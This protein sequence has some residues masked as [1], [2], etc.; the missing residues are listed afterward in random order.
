MSSL[1]TS[2]LIPNIKT[3]SSNIFSSNFAIG[4]AKLRGK[5]LVSIF[6]S[7]EKI[8]RESLHDECVKAKKN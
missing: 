5:I 1:K 3:L 7:T 4:I 2:V 6:V 8:L